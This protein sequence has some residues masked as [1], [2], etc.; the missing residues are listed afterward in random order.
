VSHFVEIATNAVNVGVSIAIIGT[1]A[2]LLNTVRKSGKNLIVARLFLLGR[3]AW[4]GGSL[5][6]LGL[7]VFL[8]S[9][10]LELYGDVFHLDWVVNEVVETGSLGVILAGLLWFVAIL[11]LPARLGPAVRIQV[12]EG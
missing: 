7:F 4:R 8:S 10:V 3:Q 12:S 11:R 6:L 2:V 5:L 1:I 9:N